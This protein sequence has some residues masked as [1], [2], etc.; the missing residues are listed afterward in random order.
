MWA[1]WE[2]ESGHAGR[3]RRLSWSWLASA[4]TSATQSAT[5]DGTEERTSNGRGG[6]AEEWLEEWAGETM[7]LGI[8]MRVVA[9]GKCS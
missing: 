8:S 9:A 7:T 2:A 4:T 1:R 6:W 3:R 5:E